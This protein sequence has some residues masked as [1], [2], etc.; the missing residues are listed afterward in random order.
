MFSSLLAV[1]LI[2]RQ[3]IEDY[4]TYDENEFDA[5]EDEPRSQYE[6]NAFK[7]LRLLGHMLIH[8]DADIII[9]DIQ[10]IDANKVHLFRDALHSEQDED[11]LIQRAHQRLNAVLNNI[12]GQA[13]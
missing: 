13:K 6:E 12:A 9:E 2:L 10:E 7:L 5:Y 4:A 8:V 3:H 1:W 11:V